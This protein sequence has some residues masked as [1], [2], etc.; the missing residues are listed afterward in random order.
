MRRSWRKRSRYNPHDHRQRSYRNQKWGQ[1]PPM[2]AVALTILLAAG[3]SYFNSQIKV[4]KVYSSEEKDGRAALD[5]VNQFRRQYGKHDLVFDSRAFSLA[6][7]RAWD[8]RKYKYY[9]HMNPTTGSCPYT[10][11]ATYGFRPD[12]FVAENISGYPDYS[13]DFFTQTRKSPINEVVD[14]W[15]DS[16]GHRYNLL[17]DQHTAG[18][19]ACY[20]DK[21][22]F[23]G[24]NNQRFGEGCSTA[25][26]GLQHWK[27]VPLQPGEITP[28]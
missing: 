18:A 1:L 24:V 14:G 4:F 9:D 21:C 13:E 27:A 12:E 28:R 11:K 16:R 23:L 5:Y 6:M 19:V 17:Y 25:A 7:M 26:Q 20:K 15:M 3:N 10:M 8:M 22:V 2:I